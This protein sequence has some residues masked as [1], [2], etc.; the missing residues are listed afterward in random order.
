M[1]SLGA[2]ALLGLFAAA[3]VV[4]WVS[5]IQLSKAT[6]AL[7]RRLGLGEALG[8]LI[9]LGIATSLPELA[10]TASAAVH[11]HLDLAIGNLLGGIA[12]Q[13]VVLA[14]LDARAPRPARCRSWSARLRWSSKPRPS[15]RS[16]CW[17]SSAPGFRPA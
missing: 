16:S 6:D 15:S 2:V 17:R 14:A 4:T 12:I 7:D 5:G 3:A 11:E 8:G 10:I 1:S 9:L 13:T